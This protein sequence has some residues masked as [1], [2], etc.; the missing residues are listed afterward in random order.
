ME[1]K[2]KEIRT[3]RGLAICALAVSSGVSPSTIG[4]I[5]RHGYCP[6]L[7]TRQRLADALDMPMHEI[8]PEPESQ[9]SPIETLRP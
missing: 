1:S 7:R 5:E 3:G 6:A 2:L 4:W 9:N 8:W